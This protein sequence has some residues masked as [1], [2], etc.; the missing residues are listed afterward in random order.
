M[1]LKE[2]LTIINYFESQIEL[3]DFYLTVSSS[4]TGG[5]YSTFWNEKDVEEILTFPQVINSTKLTM[6]WRFHLDNIMAAL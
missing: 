2:L 3:K 6:N 4:N 1:N 5:D